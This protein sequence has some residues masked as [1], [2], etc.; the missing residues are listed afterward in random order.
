MDVTLLDP[1]SATWAADLDSV[2]A[3]L[4]GANNPTLFPYHFLQVT[5]PRIGGQIAIGS[6]QGAPVMIGLLFPRGYDA[7]QAISHPAYT[8]RYYAL[9][10][11]APEERLALGQEFSTCLSGLLDG[12]SLH[13]YDPER[14][15]QFAAT[16]HLLGTVDVGRPNAAEAAAVRDLQRQVWGSAPEFLYPADMHSLDFGLG[17]SLVARVEQQPIG[18]LFGFSKFGGS[19]LPADWQ[20]RF[21]GALRLESQ[22]L[23]VLTEFRGLRIGHLLKKIQAEQALQS[24]IQIINWTVDPLQYPNAALNF[25]ML[26]ALAFDFMPDYYPFRNELN[27]V[28][29]SRFSLTWPVGSARVRD[30]LANGVQSTAINLHRHPSIP[31]VNDGFARVDHNIDAPLI[32]IEIPANWTALQQEGLEVALQWRAATDPLFQHYIGCEPGQYVVTSAGVD[33]E[34]RFLIA[35]QV[36]DALWEQLGQL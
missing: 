12:L 15:Q 33:Q 17:T 10:N 34:R 21:N 25:G 2:Y 18:F 6:T 36:N 7:Q 1:D 30:R 24:G 13:L 3:Q 20:E 8:L 23:G 28:H 35:E 9:T 26:G 11:L 4:G 31:R 22:I 14:T 27:R 32:A 5:F 16:H 19:S 29:A